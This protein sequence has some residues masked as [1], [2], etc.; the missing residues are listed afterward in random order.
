M[1]MLSLQSLHAFLVL[2][3]LDYGALN[4]GRLENSHFLLTGSH[5]S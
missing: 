4:M 2:T 5:L 1:R 3:I